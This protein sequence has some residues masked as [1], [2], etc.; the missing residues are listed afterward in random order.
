MF[1]RMSTCLLGVALPVVA[2]AQP[3]VN[4]SGFAIELEACDLGALTQ[5]TFAPDG[6]LYAATLNGI[7]WSFDYGGSGIVSGPSLAA[8][9]QGTILLGVAID[10]LDGSMYVSSADGPDDT[11]FI[12]RL[13]DTNGDGFFETS[14]RFITGL[15][16]AGHHNDQLALDGRLLYFGMGSRTDDGEADNVSPVPAATLLQ[17][18]LD[19][20]DF[21]STT[22]LPSVYAFGLRNAFGITLSEEGRVWAGDNGRDSPLL[23]DT[24]HL[25][26]PGRHHG[27]PS[28]LAPPDAVAPLADLGLGT[29]SD[30]CDFYPSSGAWGSAYAR[31]LFMARFDFEQ[32]NPNSFGMDVIRVQLDEADPNNPIA[33]VSVFADGLNTPLDVEL[34]PC[35]NLLVMQFNGDIYRISQTG[36]L[37]LP[38][39][40]D[41]DCDVDLS[42]LAVLLNGFGSTDVQYSGA[43]FTGD[44]SVDLNDL[45]VLLG[46]FGE[47][48]P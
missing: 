39:D 28:E 4:E 42:D 5:I 30:G 2:A 24:L 11:G 31:N 34:D 44:C 14:Q 9:G 6:T 36:T 13:R 21:T 19:T 40:V 27:F 18:D 23:P 22:N 26:K 3:V 32:D 12:A 48:C 17:V 35:G 33:S 41:R 16:N 43:D 37:E 10:P 25:V 1:R 29:S 46:Q 45:A 47:Q 38:G 15:P 8:S 20:V 7:V